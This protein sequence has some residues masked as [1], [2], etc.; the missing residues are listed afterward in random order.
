MKGADNDIENRPDENICYVTIRCETAIAAGDLSEAM[1]E[2]LPEDGIILDSFKVEYKDGDDVFD[3]ILAAVKANKIHMEYIGT[4][5]MPYIEGVAN[6]YEFD[7]GA[8]SGRMY[9]VN[10]QVPLLRHG[11]V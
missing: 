11:A 9:Q 2:I 5:A 10:G 7:C 6:L 4:T 8:T 1:L 3:A